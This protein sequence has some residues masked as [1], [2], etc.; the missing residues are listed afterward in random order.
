MYMSIRRYEGVSPE[1]LE[2]ITRVVEDGFLAVISKASGFVAFYTIDAG[3]SVIVSVSIF[4]SQAGME[5]SNVLA[6]D[7]VQEHMARLIPNPPQV[8]AGTLLNYKVAGS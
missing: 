4:E 2:K 3:D 6:A 1:N 5:E 7:Y 8:T